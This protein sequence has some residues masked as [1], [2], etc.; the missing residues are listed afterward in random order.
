MTYY[1]MN[2]F[3][4]L[5]LWKFLLPAIFHNIWEIRMGVN[6]KRVFKCPGPIDNGRKNCIPPSQEIAGWVCE[7]EMAI[8]IAWLGWTT[9]RSITLYSGNVCCLQFNTHLN[10]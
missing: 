3:I 1:S 10:N 4:N 7:W 8:F 5:Y 2:S 6:G 9:S